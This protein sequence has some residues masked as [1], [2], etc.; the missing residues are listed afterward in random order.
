MI[1]HELIRPRTEA[2]MAGRLRR[3]QEPI[4]VR[5]KGFFSIESTDKLIAPGFLNCHE[6]DGLVFQPVNRVRKW[7]IYGQNYLLFQ[8]YTA[9]RYDYLL[10]WKPPEQSSIDFR[11]EVKKIQRQGELAQWVAELHVLHMDQPFACMK[12]TKQLQKLNGRIIECKFVVFYHYNYSMGLIPIFRE[13]HGL[14]NL[15]GKGRIKATQ[16]LF[17]L[18]NQCGIQFVIQF[19]KM[20]SWITFQNMLFEK[21][22]EAN[23]YSKFFYFN[24][25]YIINHFPF[26]ISD[27]LM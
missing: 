13:K 12:A 8:P 18:L 14:G 16:M 3:D 23:D 17:Q 20:T 5:R 2:F 10:K 25:H 24:S 21:P 9:G 22:P 15:C 6:V 26:L 27:K 1:E 19:R 7:Q 4:G 11:L